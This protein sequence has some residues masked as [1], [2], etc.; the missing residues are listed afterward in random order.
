M[1]PDI[2]AEVLVCGAG[3]SGFAAACCAARS[4]A[5]VLLVERCGSVGGAAYSNLVNPFMVPKFEGEYLVKGIF[6]EVISRLK[7]QNACAEGSLFDQPHIVFDPEVLQSIMLDMLE[8]SQVKMLYHSSVAAAIVKGNEAKGAAVSGKSGEI[9]ILSSCV[10]DATGDGDMAY[11]SGCEFEKG[12][13][14]DGLCQPATLMF[15]IAGVDTEKMS[16]REE[17]NALYLKARSAGRIRSPRENF[18][19]FETVR[20]GEIHI[21]STRIPKIDGTDVLDLTKAEVEGRKQVSNLYAFLKESVPGFENSYISRVANLVGIRESRRIKG[22]YILTA[23]DIIEGKKFDDTVAKNNYPIDIHAPEGNSTVFKKLGPGIYYEI[24][25]RCMVPKKIDGLL[26]TGRA[27]SSTH[28][29]LS[30]LRIMPVCMALGQA[31]GV[32]AAISVKKRVHPRMLDYGD[33]RKALNEQ[34]ADLR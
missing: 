33:L 18:L 6:S 34:E 16:S 31:A 24:P 22:K 10:I 8:E 3:L 14:L 7:A 17:I 28:E 15:R 2:S 1:N 27:I 13:A 11:L 30:S 26:V 29:A 25:Y 21:N 32:A 20:E 9:K 5:K 19:W 23:E 12:R 4:G